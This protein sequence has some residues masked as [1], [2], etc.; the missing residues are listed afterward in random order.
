[1]Y[2]KDDIHLLPTLKKY[3]LHLDTKRQQDFFI[4]NPELKGL[5]DGV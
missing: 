5:F 2:S 4:A 3:T 1:M